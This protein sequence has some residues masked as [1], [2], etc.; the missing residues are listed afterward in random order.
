MFPSGVTMKYT[1]QICRRYSRSA[2]VLILRHIKQVHSFSPNFKIVCDLN[3]NFNCAATYVN[4]ESFRSHVYKK[5]KDIVNPKS[6]NRVL[7]TVDI[8]DNQLT[9]YAPDIDE[10]LG[11]QD[12][13]DH[14]S[15]DRG[16][17]S[18]EFTRS[19]ALFILKTMEMHKTSQVS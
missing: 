6:G 16:K 8:T 10:S 15:Q 13:V 5:H 2:Y 3:P 7:D 12:E 11:E 4:Y 19:V 17:Q 9:S 14:S 18:E 1:C